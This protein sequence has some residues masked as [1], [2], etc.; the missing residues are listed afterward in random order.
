MKLVI[1]TQFRE[2]YGAHD[3]DGKGSCPQYW[4]SKGGD[5]YVIDVNLSE[6]QDPGFYAEVGRCIAHRSDY[7]EEYIIGETL[8]DDIDFKESDHIE[9]WDS[10]IYAIK[11]SDR[12]EL[13]CKRVA[14]GYDM[15]ATPFG[16]RSWTQTPEGSSDM[17]LVTFEQMEE[18]VNYSNQEVA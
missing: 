15:D 4:K 11:L 13:L 14:R 10:A 3:W 5:C 7:S 1:Q 18:I 2:N 9:E 8:V 12:A 6:A 16:E 17:R